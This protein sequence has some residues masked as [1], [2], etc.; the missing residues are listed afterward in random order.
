MTLSERELFLK[1]I[2]LLVHTL[3]DTSPKNFRKAGDI[4]GA[5]VY[6]GGEKGKAI[7]V[8]MLKKLA[9]LVKNDGTHG[10][11]K[12]NIIETLKA[13]DRTLKNEIQ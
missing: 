4:E 9:E 12:T 13:G 6:G 1:T 5:L 8:T 10:L 11:S 7:V 2:G 3:A